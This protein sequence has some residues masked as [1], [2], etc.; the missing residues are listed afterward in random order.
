MTSLTV[1]R[2]QLTNVW[3]DDSI[4]C[5]AI[6]RNQ[7]LHENVAIASLQ[8]PVQLQD[9]QHSGIQPVVYLGLDDARGIMAAH[10]PLSKSEWPTGYTPPA[11]LPG[12]LT[13]FNATISSNERPERIVAATKYLIN[14]KIIADHC[15]LDTLAGRGRPATESELLRVHDQEHVDK[16]LSCL[17]CS[18]CHLLDVATSYNTIFMNEH[19]VQAALHAAGLTIEATRAVLVSDK[20]SEEEVSEETETTARAASAVCVVRPPGHHSELGCAM[21]FGLFNTVAIAAADALANGAARVLVVDWD[22]HHGNGTQEIFQND[23]R[24]LYVSAHALYSFPAFIQRDGQLAM[25]SPTFV[26][27]KDAQGFSVNCGWQEQGHGDAEYL[28]MMDHLIMPI[29]REFNPD[30]VLVS[31]GFDSAA[32]DEE[33]YQVTP[34]GY[35]QMIRRLRE[36]AHGKI[37]VVLE[38]GYNIPAVCMGLHAVV[39]ELLGV[40]VLPGDEGS[41]KEKSGPGEVNASAMADIRATLSAQRPFWTCFQ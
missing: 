22:I 33:G 5:K 12:H 27:G 16:M 38:G 13:T 9:H 23:K 37:V 21:G 26:G 30:L 1:E 31:A 32:G 7:T 19:S 18:P 36:L 25:Q 34:T 35:A 10:Q 29:A 6:K 39:G 15:D 8:L 17:Q 24:V 28:H 3:A 4:A 2:I 40:A 11:A 41:E 20:V 14:T